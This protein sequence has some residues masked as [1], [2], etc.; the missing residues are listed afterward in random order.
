MAQDA[1]QKIT[2]AEEA[3]EKKIVAANAEAK[4]IVAN[5]EREGR[6]LVESATREADAKVAEMLA[7]AEDVSASS[8]MEIMAT[9]ERACEKLRILAKG[10]M[11][12]AAAFIAE[13]VVNG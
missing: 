2:V 5:A 11:R 1:I 12:D 13:K 9:A 8:T 7:K 4:R 6:A 3:A 10:R